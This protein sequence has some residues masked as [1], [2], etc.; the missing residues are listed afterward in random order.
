MHRTKE[1]GVYYTE[2]VIHYR[3]CR[4]E[5]IVYKDEISVYTFTSR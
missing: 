5:R 2:N 3:P 4:P 1:I